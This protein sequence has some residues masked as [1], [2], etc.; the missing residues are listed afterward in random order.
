MMKCLMST[1]DNE[2]VLKLG[3]IVDAVF[4]SSQIVQILF[5]QIARASRQDKR[6]SKLKRVQKTV[7]KFYQAQ[8]LNTS[9]KNR[10]TM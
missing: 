7:L 6:E 5:S 1:I 9:S 2:R 8:I 4:L 10:M 3:I